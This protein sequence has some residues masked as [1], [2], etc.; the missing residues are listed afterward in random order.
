MQRPKDFSY[1]GP[2][3]RTWQLH[4]LNNSLPALSRAR[5][6]E[7]YLRGLDESECDTADEKVLRQTFKHLILF[8]KGEANG[9]V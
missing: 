2:L 8:S 9:Q 3:L 5:I 4:E 1:R 7:Q 6:L